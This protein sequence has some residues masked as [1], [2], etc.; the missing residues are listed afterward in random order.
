MGSIAAVGH[1]RHEVLSGGIAGND[2]FNGISKRS[3][4]LAVGHILRQ[5]RKR[6]KR[7]VG[8]IKVD[9]TGA[10]LEVIIADRLV[11]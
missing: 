6:G 11:R 1:F 7:C 3:H 10:S 4:Q 2:H 8:L 5:G 9:I